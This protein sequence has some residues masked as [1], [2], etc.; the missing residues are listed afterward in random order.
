MILA[1]FGVFALGT[2]LAS[3]HAG[4]LGLVAMVITVLGS[5]LSIMIFGVSTFAAPAEGQAYLV[6]TEEFAQLDPGFAVAA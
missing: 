4:P 1:I 5:S 3:S 2:Y 6:G